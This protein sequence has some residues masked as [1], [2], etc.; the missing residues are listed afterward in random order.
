[1]NFILLDI[2]Y[3]C[4]C[5]CGCVLSD[6]FNARQPTHIMIVHCQVQWQ[7]RHRGLQCWS[8]LHI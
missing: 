6:P 3:M 2:Y 8:R 1:L 7:W 4:V 5:V